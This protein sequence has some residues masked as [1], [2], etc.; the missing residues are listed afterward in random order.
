[1]ISSVQAVIL[2]NLFACLNH[3]GRSSK[4]SKKN[5]PLVSSQLSSGAVEVLSFHGP[6][7]AK[8]H[9]SSGLQS[10]DHMQFN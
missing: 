9:D 6:F 7:V 3:L 1:M 10:I 5:G 8:L 2:V 4:P